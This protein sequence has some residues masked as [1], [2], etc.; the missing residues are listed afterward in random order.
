MN[1][2][3]FFAELL[4]LQSAKAFRRRTV[5]CIQPA[6]LLLELIY[7]I[8]DMVHNF[9]GKGSVLCNGLSVIKF[10]QLSLIHI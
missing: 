1:N 6:V 7:L 5:D 2:P 10:L 8:V 3:V 4:N 9:Q